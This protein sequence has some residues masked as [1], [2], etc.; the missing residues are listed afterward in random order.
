MQTCTHNSIEA[1]VHQMLY[2]DVHLL[3][4]GRCCWF[5]IPPPY[6]LPRVCYL[7]HWFTPCCTSSTVITLYSS[8]TIRHQSPLASVLSPSTI[9]HFPPLPPTS[10][11]N[12]SHT[13]PTALP[14][15]G[16]GGICPIDNTSLYKTPPNASLTLSTRLYLT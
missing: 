10:R 11:V 2:D 8:H 14:V 7:I 5:N 6:C 16:G 12:C 1:S 4:N 3:R 9:H 13:N 15:P